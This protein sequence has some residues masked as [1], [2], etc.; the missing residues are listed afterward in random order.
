[1]NELVKKEKLKRLAT[2]NNAVMGGAV[3]AMAIGLALALG[4]I[5]VRCGNRTAI[6]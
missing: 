4:K 1:M 2:S 6:E 5:K 3:G